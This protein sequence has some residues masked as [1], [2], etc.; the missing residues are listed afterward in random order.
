M[1]LTFMPRNGGDTR[2]MLQLVRNEKA[3]L[4]ERLKA[5]EEREAVILGWIAQ[6]EGM[7]H[8]PDQQELLPTSPVRRHRILMRGKPSLVE[9]LKDVIGDGEPRSNADLAELAV[10]RGIV[11]A[12]VD[13]RSIN[14]TMLSLLNAG[15]VERD[16]ESSTW[17]STA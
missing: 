13:L 14:S 3:R 8:K 7:P 9:F 2:T 11:E 5:L 10:N 6:E 4:E 15:I 17:K 16:K 1:A 12:G